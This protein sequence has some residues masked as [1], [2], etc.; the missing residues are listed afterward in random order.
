MTNYDIRAGETAELREVPPGC[1]VRMPD[2][3]Q[4]EV[5]EHNHGQY[6]YK[7]HQIKVT[8]VRIRIVGK[9]EGGLADPATKVTVLQTRKDRGHIG[10]KIGNLVHIIGGKHAG[11]SG[12]AIKPAS[13]TG[14]VHI[15]SPDHPG[16]IY[17]VQ[18][19]MVIK[20][21]GRLEVILP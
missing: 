17:R 16:E 6:D 19:S 5:F 2:G 20:V 18:G 21:E 3:A 7:T 11:K 1:I 14:F 9:A 15:V 13:V 10:Y 12:V 4:A 8:S